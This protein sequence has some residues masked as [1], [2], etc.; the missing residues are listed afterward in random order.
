MDVRMLGAWPLKCE[1]QAQD[2]QAQA[3]PSDP[4]LSKVFSSGPDEEEEG[5]VVTMVRWILDSQGL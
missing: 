2:I 4:T 3:C 5:K 1:P